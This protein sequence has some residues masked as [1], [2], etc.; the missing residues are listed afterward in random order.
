[1]TQ[2]F[3]D[4]GSDFWARMTSAPLGSLS[5]R[6]MELTFLRA[7]LDAGLVSSS[8]ADL[9][10]VFRISLTKTR[11]YL[12]DLAVRAEPLRDDEALRLLQA[13]LQE[14]EIDWDG[15]FVTIQFADSR[16]Y[17]WAER[18]LVGLRR[19][20]GETLRT[21][22]LRITLTTLGA[23]LDESSGVTGPSETLDLLRRDFGETEWFQ[24]ARK[25]IPP[26]S[27]WRDYLRT[28]SDGSSV[29]SHLVTLVSGA[30]G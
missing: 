18:K 28:D 5:K 11:S 21:H 10:T 17:V 7:A 25:M 26:K 20:S 27:K 22:T 6:E 12:N 1:M 19:I 14:S 30:L 2:N 15:R 8:Q 3:R 29:M 24:D 4:F 13:H 16:L 23:L 9:A